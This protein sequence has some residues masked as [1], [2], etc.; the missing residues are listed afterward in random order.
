MEAVKNWLKD[1]VEVTDEELEAINDIVET[2]LVK[3]NEVV[4]KQGDIADKIGLLVQGAVRTYFTDT[5]GNERTISFAF[6]G[7]PMIAISSFFNRTPANLACS[8]LEPTLFVW[9]DYERYN[10]FVN[11]F[12]HYNTVALTALGRGLGQDKYRL[13]YLHLTS[14]K[15]RYD[16]M[17]AMHP[18][19][20]ERVPLKYIASYLGIT[21]ETLSR[22]RAKK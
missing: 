22:I 20:I 18:K 1:L 12:P 2:T 7:D 16:G 6:E 19:I 13:E 15:E 9:T 10:S 8:T 21:Q 17:C 3:P 14:A 5:N 4:L 11:R